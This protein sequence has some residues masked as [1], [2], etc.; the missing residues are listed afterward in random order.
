MTSLKWPSHF[1]ALVRRQY[2]MLQHGSPSRHLLDIV[3]LGNHVG[4]DLELLRAY[5]DN[6]AVAP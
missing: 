5:A 1:H 4:R 6:I 2:G 3:V